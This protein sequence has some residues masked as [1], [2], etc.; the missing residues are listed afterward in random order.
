M[1]FDRS[2]CENKQQTSLKT[3]I[4]N[5]I[6]INQ[7]VI[8]YGYVICLRILFKFMNIFKYTTFPWLFLNFRRTMMSQQRHECPSDIVL[9][10]IC[11]RIAGHSIVC[12]LSIDTVFIIRKTANKLA[13]KIELGRRKLLIGKS[14]SHL[15][16]VIR[17]GKVIYILK[18][19]IEKL[20]ASQ[21]KVLK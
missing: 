14:E 6:F 15:L 19:G 12:V 5:N 13:E 1:A 4:S 8:K 18:T 21:Q 2:S 3:R 17:R 16:P 10:G 11:I 9:E 20:L 7:M